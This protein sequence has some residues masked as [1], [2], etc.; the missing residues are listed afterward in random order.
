MTQVR[1]TPASLVFALCFIAGLCEGYD[2]QS[3]GITAPKFAPVFHL[4]PTQLGWVFSASTL[5]LFIGALIGGRLADRVGRRGVLIASGLIV[6]ESLVGVVLAGIIGASGSSAPLALVGDDFAGTADGLGLGV[7]AIVAL[8]IA[9]RVL[10][11]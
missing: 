5:G 8:F 3:A 10:K 6:G 1:K 4:L 9:R 2:L 11:T 7:F